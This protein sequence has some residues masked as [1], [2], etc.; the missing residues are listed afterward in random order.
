MR[1]GEF[2]DLR[3]FAAIVEHGS[4]A[5]AAAHLG[6]SPS[7]LSQTIRGLETRLGVRLLNRTTRSVA[8]TEGGERLLRTLRPAFQQIDTELDAL[9]DLRE[10]PA[11]TIRIT[12]SDHAAITILWPAISRVLPTYPDLKV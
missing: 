5:R 8:P 12:A 6:V 2:A 10:K 1:G 3:A 4:F 7:A 9:G 11:G